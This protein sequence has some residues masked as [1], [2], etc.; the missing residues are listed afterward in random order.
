MLLRS[1]F[2]NISSSGSGSEFLY[3]QMEFCEGKTLRGWID[4]RNDYPERRQEATTIVKQ[5]LEAVKYVHAK[6]LIH[7]DL[8]VDHSIKYTLAKLTLNES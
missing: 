4:E 7:R 8:K 6:R 3:I 1:F 5:V 2:L